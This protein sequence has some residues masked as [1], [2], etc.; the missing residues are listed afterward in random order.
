MRKGKIC[1]LVTCLS[2]LFSVTAGAADFTSAITALNIDNSGNVSMSVNKSSQDS[3]K[4]IVAVYDTSGQLKSI[5]V[6]DEVTGEGEK[7][8]NFS[9]T[10]NVPENAIVKAFL[11]KTDNGMFTLEP[12]TD[13]YMPTGQPTFAPIQTDTPVTEGYKA[14]F[15]TD[16][17]VTVTVSD[18]QDFTNANENVTEAYARS[19]ATGEV[20]TSGDGQVNFMVVLE[21]GYEV[22]S[23]TVTPANYKNLKLPAELGANTY[24]ITK[25]TGD[26]TVTITT[27]E[28]APAPTID[29]NS[30]PAPGDG[31]IHLNGTSINADGVENVT[32]SG[33][34][35]TITAAGTYDVEGTLT[36]GQIKV[37][38]ASPDDEIIVNLNNVNVT[39][40]SDD[41]FKATSG[42]VTL[43]PAADTENT[44]SASAD[45]ACGIYSKND[46]AVKGEGK[47][48]AN[49]ALGNGIRCKDDLE[50]GVCDLYVNAGNNGI[51]GDN[52][53]KI[54]KKNKSVTVVSGGDGIKSDKEP[55]LVTTHRVTIRFS[56]TQ[57]AVISEDAKRAGLPLA[58]YLR[59]LIANHGLTLSYKI[60]RD[61]KAIHDLTIALGRIGNNLN[62]ISRYFHQ[63]GATTPG[64]EKDISACISKIYDMS[65]R[66]DEIEGAA[67]GDTET[68]CQ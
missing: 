14:T 4:G 13:T 30:T 5:A 42:K 40:T 34:T 3:G 62:Q 68:H 48:T 54:T 10:L 29:P 11:W 20:D 50:I 61:D 51:K 67:D 52:S 33:T 18:T 63:H 37:V 47:I 21:D 64:I 56:D 46:L 15:V 23:V 57:Y 31:V 22:D 8:L 2:L 55:E 45:S 19:S 25:I 39:N 9:N 43:V 35:A 41:A 17:H 12:L 60:V 49:S 59:K 38:S 44:F 27:K 26:I 65:A 28:A 7:P 16:S 58:D 6:S 66:L 24:R 32:I 53:V 36:D 1:A